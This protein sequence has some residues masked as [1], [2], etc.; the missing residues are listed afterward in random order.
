MASSETTSGW[1]STAAASAPA[2]SDELGANWAEAV[3]VRAMRVQAVSRAV[4][5]CSDWIWIVSRV[6]LEVTLGL[7]SRS[8]PIQLP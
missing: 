7:P 4:S 6:T 5:T 1:A 8:P 3:S 2:S